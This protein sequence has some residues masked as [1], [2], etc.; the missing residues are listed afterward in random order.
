MSTSDPFLPID[1]PQDPNTDDVALEP[2]D[3]G[4]DDEPEPDVFLGQ[5]PDDAPTPEW[6]PDP[7]FQ[8]PTGEQVDPSTD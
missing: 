6:K 8:T 7:L 5:Q 1:D 4:P 2:E 3:F